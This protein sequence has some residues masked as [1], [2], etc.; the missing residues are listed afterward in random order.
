MDKILGTANFWNR[1]LLSF[2]N[3][4]GDCWSKFYDR[5]LRRQRCENL[6]RHE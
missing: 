6:Q 5:E 3:K 2:W 1:Q 4:K